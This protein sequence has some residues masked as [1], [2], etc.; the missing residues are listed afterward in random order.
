[1]KNFLFFSFLI[2]LFIFS[3]SFIYASYLALKIPDFEEIENRK[4]SQS[5]KIYDRSGKI[6]LYEVHGEEKR[7][8]IPFEE[9]P[10]NVKKATIAAEDKNFY[11][12]MAFDWK[13]II[14]SVFIDLFY[15]KRIG[16]STITQQLAK[17]SF[18]SS[19]K[20][21]TRKIKELFLAIKLE[22]R[23]NKDEILSFYLNQI[24]YG[25]NAYGIQAAAQTYFNK[26][27]SD[28]TL[29]ETATLAALPQAPSFYS[30]Y[31]SHV[32]DLKERT[33]YV[34]EQMK[35]IGYITE[36]EM[37]IAEEEK[38]V[39]APQSKSI[40]A[41]H[42]TMMVMEYLREKYGEDMIETGGLRVTTTLNEEL[43]KI[44]EEEVTKGAENN[45][46]LYKGKNM[47]LVAQDPK[48][49]Q[50]LAL[51]GS[52]NYF[53]VENEGNFNVAYQ[54]LRQPGSA[55]KPFAYIEAFK[56]GYTPE[57][58]L[59]DVPTEFTV[60][61]PNCPIKQEEF[62]DE[63]N[64]CYHPHNFDGIF[65]GPVSLKNALAQS[66][67]IPAVKILYLAGI[68]DTLKLAENF[69]I[70]TLSD[71]SRFG[72]SLVL[73]GGEVK[74]TELVNAYSVFAQDGE[75]H[76]QAIILKVEDSNGKIIEE[77]RDEKERV[78]EEQYARMIN[79]V[80]S[81]TEARAGLF[82]GS[83]NLTI[84]PE[85]E[86]AMKTGTTNDYVDAWTMGY[87]PSLVVGVWAGNNRREPMERQGGSILA[88]MPTWSSFLRRALE[89]Y[90]SETFNKPE[91]IIREKPILRGDYLNNKQVHSILYYIDKDN[92]LGL[93]PIYP[94]SDPQ[95]QNW[96]DPVI[97]WAKNN[98]PDFATYNSVIEMKN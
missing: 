39:F 72:L 87:T 61:N 47:A 40:K 58:I 27:V 73:G 71:R 4:I 23:Y 64:K 70:S 50:I 35:N 85:H 52:A 94:A 62:N 20:I 25:G 97:E 41:P 6:M 93:N 81:D 37:K 77:Y 95:F 22:K 13:A 59:F 42:F 17:N 15:N 19:D 46:E 43:Q 5:T 82:Q 33:K 31:G 45:T 60:N 11:T 38:L 53:D 28:L 83:L 88:A 49:G 9:I 66:I 7:T 24:P 21:L 8:I 30:P 75:K 26:N 55:F 36:E 57:T 86:V 89:N 65:K 92:P 56:K 80:L 63:N 84:F 74:L 3:V 12:H 18:L 78:I 2:I 48:T 16:G 14:R 54:G 1:M 90:E 98:I 67:N 32:E 29:A 96:E 76:K 10:E 79:D 69:G 34:L 68:E 91:Q 51:V 44:A